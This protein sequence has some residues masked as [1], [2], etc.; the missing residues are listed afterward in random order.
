MTHIEK[1]LTKMSEKNRIPGSLL[2]SGSNSAEMEAAALSF[3]KSLLTFTSDSHPD[4]FYY[5]PEG[6]SGMHSIDAMRSLTNEVY[7][8]PYAGKRKVFIVKEAHRMMPASSNALLKTFEEPAAHSTIILISTRPEL[9]LPT[10]VSRCQT[11]YFPFTL[12][13]PDLE[14][15]RS[16]LNL[17]SEAKFHFT[18]LK[19]A[20]STYSDQIEEKKKQWETKLMETAPSDS[21]A[22]Q[23]QAHLKEVQGVIASRYFEEVFLLFELILLWFRDLHASQ[24]GESLSLTHDASLI[25]KRLEKGSIPPLESIISHIDDAKLHIERATPLGSALQNLF[26]KIQALN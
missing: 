13:Q 10:I 14:Q 4:L 1:I 8:A 20:I 23:K 17:L 25:E 5:S 2:F 3:A 19:S 6:K 9:L 24:I 15:Y 18:D 16:I 11:L 26:L 12:T 22:L 21:T 7:L